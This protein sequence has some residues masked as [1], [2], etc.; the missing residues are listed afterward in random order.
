MRSLP[1]FIAT[2]CLPLAARAQNTPP[3][4]RLTLDEAIHR[5]LDRNPSARVA[6]LDMERAAALTREARAASLP[7]L[8]LN[9]SLIR[10]DA[11]RVTTGRVL[12]SQDQQSANATLTVPLLAPQ[13]WA[14]WSQ[15]SAQESAVSANTADLRRQLALATA[16][17]YLAVIAQKRLLETSERAL[18][19]DRAHRTFTKTRY[20]G[21]LGTRVDDIR[22]AQQV[23]VDEVQQVNARLALAKGKEALGVL[24][25]GDAPVDTA[26]DP[27]LASADPGQALDRRE[28]L[29]AAKQ[30]TIVAEKIERE[31]Y[32]DYLP[33]LSAQIQPFY[34]HPALFTTPRTGW[35]AMLVFS[36]PLFEGGLR[37]GQRAERQALL[38]QT[39]VVYEGLVRQAKSEVRLALDATVAADEALAAA[40]TAAD[41]AHEGLKLANL[42]Y[43][44]GA[45]TNIEVIDAERRARDADT[46]VTVAEDV[47]RQARLDLLAASGQFP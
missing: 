45:T 41:L 11:D 46:A 33:L 47:L 23:A 10:L 14:Q 21:G 12:A 26:E 22:A 29:R 27:R 34:Q 1:L 9:A 3:I 8:T 35:Q 15:A 20:D 28:D 37:Q 30:R 39:R 38:G 43:E 42:A 16:R 18:T 36:F 5:A 32:T 25:G 40:N 4:E 2:L 31:S 17:A 7:S 19:T 44:S 6:S 13:R 24:V